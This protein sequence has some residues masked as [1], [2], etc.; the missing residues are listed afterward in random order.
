MFFSCK[1]KRRASEVDRKRQYPA[2][3]EETKKTK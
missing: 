3:E 1:D 2:S